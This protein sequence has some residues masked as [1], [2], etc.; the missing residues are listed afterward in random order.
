MPF[1]SALARASREKTWVWIATLGTPLASSDIANPTTVGQQVLQS[2]TPRIA[3][4]PSAA[5]L[6]RMPGSS[7]QLSR[8]V[9]MRVTTAGRCAANHCRSCSMEGCGVVEQ[10]VDQVEEP[11]VETGLP[12]SKTLAGDFRRVAARIV[13]RQ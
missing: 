12:C 6:A 3:A 8:G 5:I 10:A 1:A 13:N 2:P 9:M 11:A 4:A 7:S